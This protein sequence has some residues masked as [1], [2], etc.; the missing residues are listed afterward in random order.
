MQ[1]QIVATNVEEA[2][3]SVEEPCRTPAPDG[4]ADHFGHVWQPIHRYP[5][6]KLEMQRC[7]GCGMYRKALPGGTV[8]S[9][10]FGP[11]DTVL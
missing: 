1:Q 4:K 9:A 6:G 3:A 10:W 8:F 7:A 2:T 5:M 11:A